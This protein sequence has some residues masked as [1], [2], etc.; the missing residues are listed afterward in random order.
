MTNPKSNSSTERKKLIEQIHNLPSLHPEISNPDEVVE[1]MIADFIL[2]DRARIVEPLVH[3][4]QIKEQP[5][6]RYEILCQAI[7]ST[8]NNAGVQ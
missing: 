5:L 8:L 4:G 2:A 1:E 7:E 3:L 6:P